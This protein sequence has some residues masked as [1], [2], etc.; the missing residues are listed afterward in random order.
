MFTGLSRDL[1]GELVYVFFLPH[2]RWPQKQ[3]QIFATHPVAG[4]SRKFAYVYVFFFPEDVFSTNE[5][6]GILFSLILGP[7]IPKN[8][9]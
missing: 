4:Q 8:P 1:G 7:T 9:H 3:K 6:V 2:K 5:L